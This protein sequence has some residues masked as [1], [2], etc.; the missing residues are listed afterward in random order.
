MKTQELTNEESLEIITGMIGEAKRSIAKG[1]SFQFLLWGF[2]MAVANFG[3]YALEKMDYHMPYIV[4]LVTLPVIGISI[5]HGIRSKRKSGASGHLDRI[6]GR[7]WLILGISMFCTI[8][9]MYK[10]NFN[11]GAVILL[12]AG[13]GTYISGSLLRFRPLVYGGWF[14]LVAACFAF[15]QSRIDQTLISGVAIIFGYVVPGI[16][17]KKQEGE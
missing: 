2:T 5:A 16:L 9:F 1:G 15:T 17:L 12:L 6:Y 8:A 10:L 4:W 7:I 13:C 14:L 3:H 11:H